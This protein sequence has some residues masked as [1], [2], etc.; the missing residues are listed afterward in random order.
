MDKTCRSV[1]GDW[2]RYIA[3]KGRGDKGG[4]KRRVCNRNTYARNRQNPD[5]FQKQPGS[6]AA[7]TEE[8]SGR[9]QGT[10]YY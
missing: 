8:D 2:N 5:V 1:S 9:K 6:G 3:E 7:T 10:K 4:P